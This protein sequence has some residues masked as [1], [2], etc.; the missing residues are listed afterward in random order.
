MYIKTLVKS[1]YEVCNNTE[2]ELKLILDKIYD[3]RDHIS[4]KD[5][6]NLKMYVNK[7]S[8]ELITLTSSEDYK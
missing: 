5:I 3:N 7:G 6:E 8:Y 1:K 2:N 4:L